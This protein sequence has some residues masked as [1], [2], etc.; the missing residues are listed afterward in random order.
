[1][2]QEKEIPLT[3]EITIANLQAK[4]ARLEEENFRLKGFLI[5]PE[6]HDRRARITQLE[7]ELEELREKLAL[8]NTPE[9][10]DFLKAVEQEAKHQRLRWPAEHD[11]GKTDADWFWLLGWLAGK[12]VHATTPGKKLHHVITTAAA[13]LNWHAQLL[14]TSSVMRPGIKGPKERT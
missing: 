14:G 12:A 3:H 10:L 6:A 13:C 7:T 4:V 1:M 8:I 5:Q 11:E 9:I 2:S